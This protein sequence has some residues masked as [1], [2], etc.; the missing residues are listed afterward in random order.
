MVIIK[1]HLLSIL[2]ENNSGVLS[3]V[4]AL[5]SRRGYNIDSLNVG[6][7]DI[8]EVSRI[9]IA[10]CGDDYIL[11]QITKQLNK[12]IPVIKIVELK[13]PQAVFRELIILKIKPEK[14]DLSYINDLV[15][16][17]RGCIIDISKETLTVELT[18]DTDKINAFL[19]IMDSYPT[20]ELVRTGITGI[21][22]GNIQI[23]DK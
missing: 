3:K 9:T 18:G 19:S 14:D 6:T 4:V 21:Q 8:A 2:V 1:K 15:N 12:L 5:F 16:I 20:I 22:R 13:Q 17:Y 23:T 10:V 11:E 7:T